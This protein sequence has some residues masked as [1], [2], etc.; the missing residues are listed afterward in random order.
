MYAVS[1][2]YYVEIATD[3]RHYSPKEDEAHKHK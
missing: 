1:I 3:G 2:L